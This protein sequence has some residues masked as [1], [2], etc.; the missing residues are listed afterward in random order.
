MPAYRNSKYCKPHA[1][2]AF[3]ATRKRWRAKDEEREAKHN[4]LFERIV[5]ATP[6]K[7][8]HPNESVQT[9]L[10]VEIVMTPVT[11]SF[12]QWLLKK[13][14]A[15]RDDSPVGSVAYLRFDAWLAVYTVHA[16][17]ID[18]WT[19]RVAKGVENVF[20]REPI[21]GATPYI[22]VNV[23]FNDSGRVRQ[24]SHRILR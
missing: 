4:A 16:K 9:P 11:V 7:L 14:I 18:E 21:F 23:T 24:L 17:R 1:R 5:K 19:Y 15:S 2:A 13:G 22:S 10:M 12:C 3:E 20:L 6:G 8:L